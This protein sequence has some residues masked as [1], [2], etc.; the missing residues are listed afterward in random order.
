MVDPDSPAPTPSSPA[1]AAVPVHRTKGEMAH[2]Y[3]REQ[4]LSGALRPGQRLTLSAL[5][6]MLNTSQMPI[7]DA[8]VRL[9]QE[10]LVQI[11]PHTDIHVVKLEARD[12]LELFQIRA[13]LEGLAARLACENDA[14]G[15]VAALSHHNQQFARAFERNDFAEMADANWAFHRVILRAADNSH[16]TREIEDVWDRCFRFRLGY[17]LIPG[18]ARST[19][20]EHDAVIAAMRSGDPAS[21][22]SAAIL[23]V[24]QAGRDL[25]KILRASEG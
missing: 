20:A 19:I 5:A 4:I 13:V 9:E 22:A 6:K 10:G 14:P 12:A 11:T 16:L 3:L 18:R 24:E 7:R 17:K 1:Q 8:L 21:S 23:H 15:C 25:Q 2:L